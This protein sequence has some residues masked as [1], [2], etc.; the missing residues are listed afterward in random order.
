MLFRSTRS[1]LAQH[2]PLLPKRCVYLTSSPPTLLPHIPHI[3][4]IPI[5]P[6]IP[7]LPWKP[8]YHAHSPFS[9]IS[10]RAPLVPAHQQSH[11]KTPPASPS[12]VLPGVLLDCISVKTKRGNPAQPIATQHVTPQIQ[13]LLSSLAG[14]SV[15]SKSAS[16]GLPHHT[17]SHPSLLRPKTEASP[18]PFRFTAPYKTT[19]DCWTG[20]QG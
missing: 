19:T 16:S 17:T 6:A 15:H 4:H 14:S 3:P 8:T 18:L 7:N 9:H 20:Y 11:P 2:S 13:Y 5:A 10:V 12:L 1:P